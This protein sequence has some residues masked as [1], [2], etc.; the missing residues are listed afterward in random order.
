MPTVQKVKRTALLF[1]KTCCSILKSNYEN[2]NGWGCVWVCVCM[3][4]YVCQCVCVCVCVKH[5]HCLYS[6]P[7]ILINLIVGYHR[8]VCRQFMLNNRIWNNSTV[9]VQSK[10]TQT[11]TNHHQLTKTITEVWRVLSQS[12]NMYVKPIYILLLS[13]SN[14]NISQTNKAWLNIYHIM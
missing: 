12:L 10:Y 1:P 9:L 2:W 8:S 14:L 7:V 13:A 3:R 11:N 6:C 4:M 5:L